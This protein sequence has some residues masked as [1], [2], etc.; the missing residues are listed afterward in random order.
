MPVV[1][2]EYTTYCSGC[3]RSTLR[4]W[5]IFMTKILIIPKLCWEC[6]FLG[7][8]CATFQW[9]ALSHIHV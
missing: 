3:V 2:S 4:F 7:L 9:L 1:R 5:K 6:P 8:I